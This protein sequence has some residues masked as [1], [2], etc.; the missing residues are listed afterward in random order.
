MSP[1]F[2]AHRPAILALLLAAV[3]PAHALAQCAPASCTATW[4]GV[5]FE[6]MP[7]GATVEGLGA[8]HPLLNIASVAWPFGPSCTVGSAVVIEEGVASPGSYGTAGSYPNGCLDGLKGYGD[9]QGC[10][11]DYDFTFAPGYSASCFSVRMLDY[12]DLLPFGTTTHQ[13]TMTAYDASNVVVDTDILVFGGPV[14]LVSG[15][16]CDAGPNGDP[17]NKLFTVTGAGIT[18]VT[19]TF[20]AEPDPNVGF[21]SISFCVSEDPTSAARTTWG[22]VKTLYRD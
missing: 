13:V 3:L 9:S 6:A 7:T 8:V 18:K 1:W 15:D 17:G 20:D 12:G 4:A 11:L 5:N 10:V 22:R 19:L 2:R 14:Q 21:D 16:A